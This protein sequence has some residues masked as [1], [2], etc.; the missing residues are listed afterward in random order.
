MFAGKRAPLH[1]P[2][3]L[4]LLSGG[5]KEEGKKV[6][7]EGRSIDPGVER[8]EPVFQKEVSGRESLRKGTQL[9]SVGAN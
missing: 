2:E 3:T 6:E 1:Q 9:C 7:S 8:P 5:W 4:K